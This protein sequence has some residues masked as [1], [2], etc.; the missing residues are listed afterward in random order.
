MISMKDFEGDKESIKLYIA[1]ILKYDL[2]INL[3]FNSK[4]IYQHRLDEDDFLR[5]TEN[6]IVLQS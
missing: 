3:I 2:T 1:M 4:E 6:F 5:P